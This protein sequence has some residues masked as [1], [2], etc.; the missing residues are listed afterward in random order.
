M[1]KI[2]AER[3]R[4]IMR[5]KLFVPAIRPDLFAKAEASAADAL[6]FDLEDSVPDGRKAEAR[7][8]LRSYLGRRGAERQ[9][10]KKI[11][12][13]RINAPSS[14][15]YS[16]DLAAVVPA[17]PDIINLPMVESAAAVVDLAEAIAR[18]WARGGI[19][20]LVNIETPRGLRRAPE[21]ALAHKSVIGLQIGYADLLE[22]YGMDRGD[23]AV[24]S[25][26]RVRVRF[27]AAEANIAA[28]DGAFAS[29]KDTDA[30]RQECLAARRHGFGGK[31]CIHP[32]QISVANECFY[33]LEAEIAWAK[34]ILAA[35]EHAER[36]GV[37]AILV[38]GQMVDKPFLTRA[39]AVLSAAQISF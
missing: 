2:A 10:L 16:D 7:E 30:F 11:I 20:I 13:V 5:S 37:G 21:L 1:G 15:H 39:R 29:V 19:S 6:S 12:I 36:S 35:A 23:E 32:S 4:W 17:C 27:A 25:H 22:P 26:I 8:I 24:L 9:S 3:S 28:Y 33:P 34:K 38:D 14:P 18:L 31:S